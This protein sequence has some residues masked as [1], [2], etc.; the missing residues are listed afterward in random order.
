MSLEDVRD[1]QSIVYWDP[2]GVDE[3]KPRGMTPLYDAAANVMHRALDANAKRTVIVVMTDG[4][5]N[6]SREYTQQ[7]IKDLTERCTAKE[8]EVLFLGANFDVKTYTSN[9]GLK[10][11]KMRN[12]DPTNQ[13][14]NA[15]M[16]ND[17]RAAT[18]AYAVAGQAI[19][20]SIDVDVNV[21]KK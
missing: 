21:K 16:F 19:D 14:D 18:T 7:K 17:L 20:L 2:I 9:A 6:S 12:F 1:K 3:I 15:R 13:F 5:E 11:T 10:K 4:D 8:W